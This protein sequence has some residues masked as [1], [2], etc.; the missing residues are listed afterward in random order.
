MVTV[1]NEGSA[2]ITVTAADGSGITTTCQVVGLAGLESLINEDNSA[3]I[4]TISGLLIK[5]NA[6]HEYIINLA[7]GI[8]I[9]NISGKVYKAM[10]R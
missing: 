1:I 5:K 2:V 9:L 10:V 4:Y 7:K 3:D 6:N 8:Y